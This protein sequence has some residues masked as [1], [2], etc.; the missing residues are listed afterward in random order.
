ML[1]GFTYGF[2]LGVGSMFLFDPERGPE[3][4]AR[5]RDTSKRIVNDAQQALQSATHELESAGEELSE[6]ALIERVRAK[7]SRVTSHADAIQVRLKEG[8]EIELK[9]P[10]LASEHDRIVRAASRVP[11]VESIDDDL[12]VYEHADGVMGLEGEDESRS[13][14]GMTEPGTKLLFGATIA[15]MLPLVPALLK[16]LVFATMRAIMHEA[17]P[18]V[19]RKVSERAGAQPREGE[20]RSQ[21]ERMDDASAHPT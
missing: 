12:V 4:R 19:V 14:M 10:A 7:L 9:G 21:R 3:R 13:M 2:A 6:E 20:R 17:G 8:S 15:A 16:T 1:R 18:Q 5:I 11:G